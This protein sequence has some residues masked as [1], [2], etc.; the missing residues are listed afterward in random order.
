MLQRARGLTLIDQKGTLKTFFL[1]RNACLIYI[2]MY[3]YV[4]IYIYIYIT[5]N[6]KSIYIYMYI[7]LMNSSDRGI[8]KYLEL[9]GNH[10]IFK[11]LLVFVCLNCSVKSQA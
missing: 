4:Y 8:V 11:K 2:Y 3:N 5:R 7:I 1:Q 10:L 6:I 9:L